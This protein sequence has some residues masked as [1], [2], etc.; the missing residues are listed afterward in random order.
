MLSLYVIEVF[1]TRGITGQDGF[2]NL[3]A[4]CCLL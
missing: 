4:I 1:D 2:L 3:I